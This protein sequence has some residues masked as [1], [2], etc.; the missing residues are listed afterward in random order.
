MKYRILMPDEILKPGDQYLY[1]TRWRNTQCPG[2]TARE[3][4]SVF[5]CKYR[6]PVDGKGKDGEKQ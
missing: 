4:S 5:G 3:A 6:R 2:L 1:R